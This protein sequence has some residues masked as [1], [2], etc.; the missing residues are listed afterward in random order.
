LR[1]VSIEGVQD[2]TKLAYAAEISLEHLPAGRYL[3]QVTAI[4]RATRQDAMQV[5]RFRIE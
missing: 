5:T 1:K 3:L 4:D 2:L